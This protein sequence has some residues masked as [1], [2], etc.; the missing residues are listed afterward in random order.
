MTLLLLF[1]GGDTTPPL[2]N[3]NIVYTDAEKAILGS[4]RCSF[5][6]LV[7]VA[8]PSPVR[9]WTGT[10][11]FLVNDNA[12]D[13]DDTEYLGGA[14]LI[15]LP[16]FQRMFNGL[17]ERIVYTL[18]GVSQ[19]MR[20]LATEEADDIRGAI[21]RMGIMVIGPDWAQV[22]PVRWLRRGRIDVIETSNEPGEDGERIRTIEF[23]VGSYLTG[24]KIPGSGVWTTADQNSR[25]GSEDD[26]FFDRMPLMDDLVKRWPA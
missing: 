22:G 13:P 25:P 2:P 14:R 1:Q 6:G 9:L 15:S 5:V 11:S 8:T 3:A 7:R 18:S 16:S 10:G 21:V 4:G 24:R 23:S 20:D 17:A 12:F 26:R 19:E